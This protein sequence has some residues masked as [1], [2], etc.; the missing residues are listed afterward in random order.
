MFSNYSAINEVSDTS[1]VVDMG[2]SIAI[3]A[4][5]SSGTTYIIPKNMILLPLIDIENCYPMIKLS[6]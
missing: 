1:F 3:C 2:D 5:S 4:T 6:N